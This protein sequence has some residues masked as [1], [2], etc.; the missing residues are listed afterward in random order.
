MV[1]ITAAASGIGLAAATRLSREGARLALSDLRLDALEARAAE[2]ALPRDQLICSATDVR[3][4]RQIEAFVAQAAGA[5]GR[6]DVLVNNAG[7]GRR[8]Q[9]AGLADEDWRQVM[10]V[11][12]DSVFYGARAALPHLTRTRGNIVNIASISGLAGDGGNAAYNAAKGAVV[13]LTRAMAVDH[14]PD[15]VR[16]NAVCPGLT[17]T[18]LTRKMRETP[19]VMDQFEERIPLARAGEADEIAAA[20]AFLAS[21]EASYV[22]GVSLAV[23][24]GLTA[25]TGQPVWRPKRS[26]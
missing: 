15:G 22:T 12:L 10:D 4:V 23:D 24:G 17:V 20:I 7:I 21:D 6:I 11:T 3:D 8:G 14:G 19:A 2:L 5:F 13:N 9:V 1:L 18:P 26:A 16:V 25:W